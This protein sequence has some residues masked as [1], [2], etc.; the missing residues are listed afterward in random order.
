MGD[1]P[2][3]KRQKT[4]NT[5]DITNED[6]AL[7]K[8]ATC[9]AYMNRKNDEK[10]VPPFTADDITH[11]PDRDRYGVG[12]NI[13]KKPGPFGEGIGFIDPDGSVKLNMS[14]M[15][16]DPVGKQTYEWFQK[17]FG[18]TDSKLAEAF[19]TKVEG[20]AGNKIWARLKAKAEK[21]GLSGR[22][23]VKMMMDAAAKDNVTEKPA[24]TKQLVKKKNPDDEEDNTLQFS[25]ATKIAQRG[26]G[27][28][29]PKI[30]EEELQ[31]IPSALH[32][33]AGGD[34]RPCP[35]FNISGARIP[36]A[37][38]FAACAV[39]KNGTPYFRFTGRVELS[40]GKMAWTTGT[41]SDNY[42]RILTIPYVKKITVCAAIQSRQM[43]EE[44]APDDDLVAACQMAGAL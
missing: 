26:D 8:A 30:T 3:A 43:E 22:D 16:A 34:L 9:A 4:G 2:T 32:G 24:F 11:D 1:E 42:N 17:E 38:F 27:P 44:E 35:F 14:P 7:H 40:G 39:S 36:W 21:K 15:P 5:L 13:D 33:L 25:Y 6:T 28:R 18:F 23:A 19:F 41:G 12:F 31:N 10:F 29:A 20:P 37:E